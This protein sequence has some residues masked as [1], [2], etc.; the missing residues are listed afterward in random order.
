MVCDAPYLQNEFCDPRIFFYVF[1]LILSFSTCSQIF[2]KLCPWEILGANVHKMPYIACAQLNCCRYSRDLLVVNKLTSLRCTVMLWIVVIRISRFL[3]ETTF[4]KDCLSYFIY[5]GRVILLIRSLIDQYPE[6]YLDEL[7]DWIYFRTGETCTIPTLSGNLNKIGLAVKK[8]SNQLLFSP[9]IGVYISFLVFMG[10]CRGK[11]GLGRFLWH[12]QDVK[13][14]FDIF[15]NF[16]IEN[17]PSNLTYS[18]KREFQ[19][20]LQSLFSFCREN[21]KKASGMSRN[22]G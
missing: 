14:S 9:L 12:P 11:N 15:A 10:K 7:R 21:V 4:K 3:L 5:T 16:G 17:I 20:L 2:K 8:V 1:N 6:L 13:T 18:T 19:F 22:A